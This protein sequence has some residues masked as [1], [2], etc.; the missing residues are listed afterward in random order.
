MI[1]INKNINSINNN[2]RKK[3]KED[4]EIRYRY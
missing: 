2:K 1:L 3:D 4:N